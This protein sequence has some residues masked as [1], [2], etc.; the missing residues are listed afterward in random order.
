MNAFI[1]ELKKDQ[2]RIERARSILVK[3]IDVTEP[4][5]YT[6]IWYQCICHSQAI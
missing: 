2:G 6:H 3:L 1:Y 4:K 5:G